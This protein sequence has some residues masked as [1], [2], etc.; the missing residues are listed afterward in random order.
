MYI[1]VCIQY[2]KGKFPASDNADKKC[3]SDNQSVMT[4]PL[5]LTSD[6]WRLPSCEVNYR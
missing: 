1:Y 6:F 5:V 2:R 4:V 3:L